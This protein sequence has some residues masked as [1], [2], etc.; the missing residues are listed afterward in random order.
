MKPAPGESSSTHAVD[1]AIGGSR[2]GISGSAVVTTPMR[3]SVRSLIHASPPPITSAI[4]ELPNTTISVFLMSV[5][6]P[7]SSNVRRSPLR[8]SWPSV[9]KIRTS[10]VPSG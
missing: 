9:K 2:N 8:S 10:T 3:A 7:G 6:R 5:S 4:A 1:P